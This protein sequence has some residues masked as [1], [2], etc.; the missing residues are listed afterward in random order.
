MFMSTLPPTPPS[1]FL[2]RGLIF[3]LHGIC[4]F[5]ITLL[6]KINQRDSLIT[7]SDPRILPEALEAPSADTASVS[8]S[9]ISTENGLS[10]SFFLLIP[11]IFFLKILLRQKVLTQ[12]LNPEHSNS[13]KFCMSH[14][15]Q[16]MCEDESLFLTPHSS[17][18]GSVQVNRLTSSHTS[19]A[20]HL[21]TSGS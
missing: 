7:L 14:L 18:G 19:D 6:K 15:W 16:K 1:L 5:E 4:H 11:C 9:S 13:V 12:A 20:S 8:I 2:K 10:G 17:R 21:P 3:D